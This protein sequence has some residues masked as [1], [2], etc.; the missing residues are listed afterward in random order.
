MIELQSSAALPQVFSDL[1]A[2]VDAILQRIG[3]DVRLGIPLGL[4]KPVELVNALYERARRDPEMR[5]TILTALSL[6]RPR[7]KGLEAALLDPFL[8]R[9]FAGV[10]QLAYARDQ[11]ANRLPPNVRI[12]EFFMTP[13][14]RLHNPRAQRDYI[15]TN[16]SFAARDVYEQGC[17]LVAQMVARRDT[18][19]GVRYSL[20]CNPDTGPELVRMLRAAEA[21][22]ERKIAIVG[23]VNRNLPYMARD[24]EVPASTFDYVIDSPAFDTALFSTPKTPV[25]VADHAVGLQASTLMRDGG[26]LQIGIGSLGDAIVSS[27]I[28]RHRDNAAYRDAL[29]ALGTLQHGEMIARFGGVAEFKRG[30]YGASE[31]FVDGFWELM[32]AGVLR[33]EVYD[34][35]AL[36]E[37]VDEGV[38]DPAALKP[39][40]LDALVARGVRLLRTQDFRRLQNHGFFADGTGYEDGRLIAPDGGTHI[41]ANLADPEARAQIAARCLG[42]RLRNGV[43][44]HGGFFLGPRSFYRALNEMTQEQRDRI[45]MTGV[46]RVNQLDLDPRLYKAQRLHARFVNTGMMATLSGAVISDG[47]DDGRVVSGVGGQ[48]NFVAQAHQLPTGR[49]ILLVRAV[50]DSRGQCSSNIVFNYA[51]C[52]IPRHLRDIVITEYGIADLRAKTD[53]DVAK[54]MINIADS[55]FQL[56]LL[57]QAQ[58]VGKIEAGYVIPQQHRDNTPQ[59]LARIFEPRSSSFPAFPFGHE[60]TGQ[61]LRLAKAMKAVQARVAATP[62]WKLLAIAAKPA[63]KV[64]S[65]VGEDLQRVGL[66]SP[67]GIENRVAR[68]LLIEELRRT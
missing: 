44:M 22:G 65:A 8:D 45:C 35:W 30:L 39:D 63:S 14:S 19:D 41:P 47:L 11:S 40:L 67:D 25:A 33:R 24:A 4:G 23:Q 59:R 7:P 17:N 62:K 27:L 60:F 64:E 28:L 43:V 16:Y 55:R 31:M 50:R 5:L 46:E 18:D 66:L 2:C 48:Y 51:H 52:T 20:S 9:V 6:E 68:A 12:V 34:F 38:C 15:S 37:L 32:R 61:E 1:D 49:S 13:G 26:T 10:P 3:R 29:D 54:A 58:K 57:A 36:Q 42:K 53:A 21:R 56:E